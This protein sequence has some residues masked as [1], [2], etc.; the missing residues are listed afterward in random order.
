MISAILHLNHINH[1]SQNEKF[2]EKSSFI[3]IEHDKNPF[4]QMEKI[5]ICDTN[6]W[7]KTPP[8]IISMALFQILLAWAWKAHIKNALTP[9]HDKKRWKTARKGKQKHHRE[10]ERKKIFEPE[11]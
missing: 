4:G 9:K 3:T 10:N 2:S 11:K 1:L 8:Y 7:S 6:Y 5:S